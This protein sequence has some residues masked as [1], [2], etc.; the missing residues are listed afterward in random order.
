MEDSHDVVAKLLVTIEV[1]ADEN[2][3]ATELPGSPPGHAA[4]D[5]VASR[6]VGSRQHHAATYGDWPVPQRRVQ[7]LFNRR[8]E[9]IEI[10]MQDRRL[11]CWLRVHEG[12]LYEQVFALPGNRKS[13]VSASLHW[14]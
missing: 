14:D 6:F 13:A 5:A 1:A 11:P 7:Q 9:G 12:N 8:I 2:E 10:G 4:A 3:I